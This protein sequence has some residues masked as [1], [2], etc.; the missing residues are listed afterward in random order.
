MG[1]PHFAESYINSYQY[2]ETGLAITNPRPNAFH[3]SQSKKLSMGGGFSGSGHLSA[4]N[5]SIRTS[6]DQEF[7]IFPV[8]EI[9]F[10]NG[11]D[12]D[13]DQDLDLSCVDCLSKIA[14]AAA[15]NQ[16]YSVLVRGHAGLHLG[17]LPTAHLDID[18]TLKMNG[19]FS[20]LA[21]IRH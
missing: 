4:F 19:K 18:K 15:T 17:A 12:L 1:I 13:I 2:D 9:A 5:A 10:G 20:G 6:D 3:V 11:A 14:V 8:P 16:S 7:A 21:S